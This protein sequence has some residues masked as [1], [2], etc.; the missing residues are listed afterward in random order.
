MYRLRGDRSST[1][2]DLSVDQVSGDSVLCLLALNGSVEEFFYIK[3][4]KIQGCSNSRKQLK[5][6]AKA[7]LHTS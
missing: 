4:H 6:K 1:S 5:F 3:Y 7:S 2:H